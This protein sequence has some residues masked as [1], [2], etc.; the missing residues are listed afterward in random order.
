MIVLRLP[1]P[2]SANNYWTVARNRILRTSV[3][4][5]YL[6]LVETICFIGKIRPLSGSVTIHVRWYRAKRIGDLDNRLKVVI[7][8]L[9][10]HAF[11]DD[12]K[13]RR[14]IAEMTDDQPKQARVEIEVEPFVASEPV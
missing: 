6:D 9:K 11:G 10:N 12:V 14:I 3:A 8:A 7:D 4:S 5:A 2:P 13:V 1:E